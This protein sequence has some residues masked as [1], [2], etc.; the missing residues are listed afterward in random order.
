MSSEPLTFESVARVLKRYSYDNNIGIAWTI[1]LESDRIVFN[2]LGLNDFTN[3]IVIRDGVAR[4]YWSTFIASGHSLANSE[5]W[6]EHLL[7]EYLPAIVVQSY[8]CATYEIKYRPGCRIE[9]ES[10]TFL[11]LGLPRSCDCEITDERALEV[12]RSLVFG[13]ITIG[14]FLEY[15]Y[16]N[17]LMSRSLRDHYELGTSVFASEQ[18]RD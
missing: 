13:E 9:I 12:C 1:H 17:Q 11:D 5:L 8:R 16:E 18:S 2:R 10:R 3:T 4:I 14:M 6:L 7:A 15:I